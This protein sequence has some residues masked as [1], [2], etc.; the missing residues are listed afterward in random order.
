VAKP[1]K[2][3]TSNVTIAGLSP[4]QWKHHMDTDE[5]WTERVENASEAQVLEVVAALDHA[6]ADVRALACNIAYAIGVGGLGSHAQSTVTRLAALAESDPKPKV[7]NRARVVHEGLAGELERAAIRRELPWLA[8]YSED[9]AP[10]AAAAI[11]DAREGVR[12]QVYLWWA[13][14]SAIP[15]AIR[16]EVAGKLAVQ[17]ERETDELTRRAAQLAHAHVRGG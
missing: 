4:A 5:D 9:A 10:Q 13:N 3:S 7:R 15:A 1:R 6:D 14:A 12:L 11:D 17:A 8:A 16:A 2:E